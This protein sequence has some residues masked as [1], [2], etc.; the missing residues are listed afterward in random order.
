M[1]QYKKKKRKKRGMPF[2]AI[3]GSLILILMLALV[4]F[5][6]FAKERPEE[7]ESSG[8]F[9]MG[10]NLKAAITQLA[11]SYDSFDP[12]LVDREEWK[13]TFITRFI[14][15]SRLS[16]DYLEMVSEKNS[17]EIST[18]ELNYIQYSLTGMELN[19]S[20]YIDGSVN[21]YDAASPLNYGSISGYDYENTEQG[22]IL[23]ADLEVGFDGTDHR[24]KRKLT[25][26]LVKNTDSCF[27]GYTVVSVIS[28]TVSEVQ[29]DKEDLVK[30]EDELESLAG[31]YEYPSD[32]G[33]GKLRIERTSEGYDISD[34]ESEDSYRFLADSSNIETIEDNRI[35][36]KYPKQVLSD[37]TVV[38]CY[39]ILEY[40]TEGID[41]Y[42]GESALGEGEFL[43]HAAKK[44]LSN[45]PSNISDGSVEQAF[46]LSANP[47][48]Y[49]KAASNPIDRNY[50]M[51]HEAAP[52][53][54]WKSALT[55]CE[56]WNQQIKFTGS[57][58]ESLLSED[59]YAV[60]Q[61][62]ISLWQ[63][64]YQ[65]EVNQSRELYG[66]NALIGGSMYTAIS[67]DLLIE[68]CRLTSFILLS[69]EYELSG[70]ASFAVN[71]AAANNDSEYSF[72]PYSFFIEYTS[73]FEETLIPYSLNEKNSD[74]LEAL[75]HETANKIEEK[76][77]HDFAE[78][79][80]KYI[81]F[82]QAL[83]TIEN[84]ISEDHNRC[85]TLK[86]N[87][88][89]LCAIELLDIVYMIGG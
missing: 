53:E 38:F 13:E 76:F 43:Y 79:T 7:S 42:Y 27:D 14:Q 1:S 28:E 26:E 87:R 52:L 85:L 62:A 9:V 81:S 29:N 30:E 75:I 32:Y 21:R 48:F 70:N 84:H 56:A 49:E 40:G 5:L 58:L 34:Y 82:I 54:I 69:Q 68:K 35:Y 36:I 46:I 78:H 74:E 63:E 8:E 44:N 45:E 19:F 24:E 10:D 22:V 25:A 20:T 2:G 83:Y 16:F 86:E 6:L 33:T 66:P 55:K 39:Y 47:D 51:D 89:K 60:L 67:G 65:E 80:D 4:F 61:N 72:S 59:D 15:N 73:D 12:D 31:E 77:G 64:Y 57:R 11:L 3:I 88:L 41:V 23:T 37:D 17:G 18:D 50:V 71:A